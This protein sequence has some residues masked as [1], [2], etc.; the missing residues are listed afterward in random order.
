[1]TVAELRELLAGMPGDAPV[2]VLESLATGAP[3]VAAR[4]PA[5]LLSGGRYYRRPPVSALVFEGDDP[6]AAER[7]DGE[8]LAT[9]TRLTREGTGPREALVIRPAAAP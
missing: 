2:L 3:A 6:T 1:M 5:W 7:L 9:E 4:E 8:A